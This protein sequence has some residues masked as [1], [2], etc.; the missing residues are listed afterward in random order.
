VIMILLEFHNRI[1]EQTFKRAFSS[2][3]P[4]SLEITIADFDGVLFH[5]STP[6]A[7]TQIRLSLSWPC[8]KELK[9]CGVENILK[10][11][12]GD[13]VASPEQGYDATLLINTESV[14]NKD[15]LIKKLAL[16]KRNV[17]A[18]PFEHC[19]REQQAGKKSSKPT[20]IQFRGD[21]SMFISAESDRVT[22]VF[23]TKFKDDDDVVLSRVFLQ[24]FVEARRAVQQAPQ[25]LVSHKEP[26]R[27]LA[28]VRA[29][30]GD[31]IG[32]VTFVLFPRHFEAA[33]MDNTINLLQT[34]RNYLHY[35]IKCSK[36]YLHCRMRARVTA[37]LK[38]LNRAR[39]ELEKEKKTASGRT[40]VRK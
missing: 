11:E 34:F 39:P 38:I 6:D 3:K 31:N 8:Y 23:S 15:E 29:E 12:Y 17:F 2:E 13:M 37:S 30:T 10:R 4:E 14:S 21:S 33:R 26:P 1:I 7:K 27:E 40:F 5:I 18:A 25:V 9:A 28:G 16:F 19:F 24:E 22:C 32:Y 35:H 36:A 20:I